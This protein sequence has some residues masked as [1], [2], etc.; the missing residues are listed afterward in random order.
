M[1]ARASVK[2]LL[3]GLYRLSVPVAIGKMH[4]D[5]MKSLADGFAHFE[6]ADVAPAP[7]T[8]LPGRSR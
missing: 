6:E 4:A 7:T 8:S 3:L 2:G 1:L 5:T